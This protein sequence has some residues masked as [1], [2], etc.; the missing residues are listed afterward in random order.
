MKIDK[1]PSHLN[2]FK[3]GIPGLL[4][5]KGAPKAKWAKRLIEVISEKGGLCEDDKCGL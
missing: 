5:E 3:V 4:F 1:K 2:D